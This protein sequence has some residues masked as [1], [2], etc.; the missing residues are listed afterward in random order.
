MNYYSK[1]KKTTETRHFLKA[2]VVFLYKAGNLIRLYDWQF[3]VDCSRGNCLEKSS[4]MSKFISRG[5]WKQALWKGVA[6]PCLALHNNN[7]SQLKS[8]TV[9]LA[10]KLACMRG[11][12]LGIYTITNLSFILAL[13]NGATLSAGR[14]WSSCVHSGKGPKCMHR[15]RK[16]PERNQFSPAAHTIPFHNVKSF[17]PE[18]VA[19]EI[20][21]LTASFK[22]NKKLSDFQKNCVWMVVR[23]VDLLKSQSL[24]A[25]NAANNAH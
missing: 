3:W 1:A 14:I 4:R 23:Q 11:N 10:S 22:C 15:M 9:Q 16:I 17:Q 5:R 18:R 19:R 25:R 6:P 7:E 12:Y 8:D 21:I 13:V 2:C 24:K 20:C